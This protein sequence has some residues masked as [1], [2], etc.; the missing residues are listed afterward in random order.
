MLGGWSP[1]SRGRG[2]KYTGL[3]Q[4][5]QWKS[6]PLHEGVD[7]NDVKS[8]TQIIAFMS[9]SS[10]GRGLKFLSFTDF[11]FVFV[12]PSSRGRG[13]KSFYPICKTF[14]KFVA[15]F[16]RAWI[17]M[18]HVISCIISVKCRPLHEGVDWNVSAT[19]LAV[20]NP[21]ALFTR[22]WIEICKTTCYK[23]YL[24]SPSS[25]GRGLKYTGLVQYRQWKRGRPLHEGVDWN[26]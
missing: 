18:P 26:H 22:A 19:P 9:P 12:S 25:R 10:R 13:L 7:W 15:L 2:L 8:A 21:V 3:V 4:Y 16:T 23:N 6:R 1:S 24:M 17:E 5:R 14:R 11:L 20:L